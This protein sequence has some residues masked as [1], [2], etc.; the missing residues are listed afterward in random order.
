LAHYTILNHAAIQDILS[1]YDVEM[2]KSYHVLSG[3]SENTNYRINTKAKSFV[4]TICELKT[5]TKS[6]ELA[7]LL[8]YLDTQNFET[9]KLIKTSKGELTTMWND[10]PVML[11]AYIEGNIIEDL[12]EDLLSYLGNELAKLHQI[13]APNYLHNEMIWSLE[14][15]DEVQIYA[16]DSSFY[17][18]LKRIRNYIE[19]YISAELPKALIHS[20]VF[21]NNIIIDK[22]REKGTIM[23]FE[24]ASY[25][26]RVFDIGMMIIGTCSK[27]K[28]INLTK[29]A[30]ILKGYQQENKLLS[31]EI[32]ALQAFTVYGAA[33][34]AFWRH[35]NFNYVKV[36]ET[37]K[38]HYRVMQTLADNVMRI[39]TKD[40]GECFKNH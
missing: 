13:D 18:W 38:N 36:D 17:I 19:S 10:K 28:V 14:N 37:M 1:N 6:R 22:N 27:G 16:P 15:F 34:V 5:I 25:Y 21:Y 32:D 8:E 2:V 24:E 3:G 9:S 39:S 29:A 23:D 40:F 35:Q 33:A 11:K 4:L 31:I 20:D 26:Y 7:A 12:S 30:N